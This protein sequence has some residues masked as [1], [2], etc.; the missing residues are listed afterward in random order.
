M[1]NLK[2][3]ARTEFKIE[4]NALVPP[5]SGRP[6]RYPF[7]DM[8]VGDSFWFAAAIYLQAAPAAAYYGK[9]NN[10]KFSV[11]KDGDGYRCWRVA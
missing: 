3:A 8:E 7:G 1:A 9:R 2:V 11:R 4:K 5:P 10:K 6:R